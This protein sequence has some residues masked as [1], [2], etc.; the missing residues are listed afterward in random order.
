MQVV[1]PVA[2]PVTETVQAVLHVVVQAFE[3]VAQA[4]VQVV[5]AV[6]KLV[7]IVVEVVLAA[8]GVLLVH[9]GRQRGTRVAEGEGRVPRRVEHPRP[10]LMEGFQDRP[11]LGVQVGLD[12]GG[13]PPYGFVDRVVPRGGVGQLAVGHA[14]REIL[15]RIRAE[16]PPVAAVR[17][18]VGELVGVVRDDPFSDLAEHL[19]HH[20]QRVGGD[21]RLPGRAVRQVDRDGCPAHP[22]EIAV[23][24]VQ[25]LVRLVQGLL[26]ADQ[27]VPVQRRAH[28]TRGGRGVLGVEPRGP[29]LGGVVLVF[30]VEIVHQEPESAR[31]GSLPR[32]LLAAELLLPVVEDRGLLGEEVPRR[33][34]GPSQLGE[35]LELHPVGGGS[36]RSVPPDVDVGLEG[37]VMVEQAGERT[38]RV[39]PV[40]MP[41]PVVDVRNL[42]PDL[43]R[44]VITPGRIELEGPALVGVDGFDL[45]VPVGLRVERPAA[46]GEFEVDPGD[47]GVPAD[48]GDLVA[49]GERPTSQQVDD[50]FPAL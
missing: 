45:A 16:Q 26:G 2:Q 38:V 1:Q 14:L 4:V 3:A 40:A 31:R 6:T 11:G 46:P 23:D 36:G 49:L 5:E 42:D 30:L 21:V 24:L 47:A 10:V 28:V 48:L 25:V 20:V 39:T 7:Q 41:R 29:Q 22:V 13:P 9:I 12:V 18:C 19:V 44:G 35:R 15:G 17:R 33:V 43:V 32:G 27:V 8:V 34:E 50:F 37:G